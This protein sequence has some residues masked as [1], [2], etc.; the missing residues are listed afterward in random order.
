VVALVE[1][2]DLPGARLA[3]TDILGADLAQHL[4]VVS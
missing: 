2:G 3:L 4:P 1:N